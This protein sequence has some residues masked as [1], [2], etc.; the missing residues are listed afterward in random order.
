MTDS[1]DLGFML[2]PRSG[3]PRLLLSGVERLKRPVVG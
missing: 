1:W 3:D 2:D